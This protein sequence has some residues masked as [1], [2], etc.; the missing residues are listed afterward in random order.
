MKTAQEYLK[1]LEPIRK[2]RVSKVVDYI[3]K[4]F[5]QIEQNKT[6]SSQVNSPV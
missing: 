1:E 2:E 4:E 3:S 6:F 5:P